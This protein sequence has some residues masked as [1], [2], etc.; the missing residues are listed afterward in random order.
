MDIVYTYIVCCQLVQAQP[1]CGFEM[2]G[3]SSGIATACTKRIAVKCNGT[4]R[5]IA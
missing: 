1:T 2:V 4:A 3:D 5:A